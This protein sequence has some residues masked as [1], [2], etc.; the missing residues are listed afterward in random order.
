MTLDTLLG[1]GSITKDDRHYDGDLENALAEESLV[2]KGGSSS[3]FCYARPW[4]MY[5]MV[6][7]TSSHLI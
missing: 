2:L 7:L 3:N 5:R 6:S 4:T 1:R